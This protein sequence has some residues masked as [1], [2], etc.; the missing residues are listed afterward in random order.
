MKAGRIT[1]PSVA[2]KF[3][4]LL[5]RAGLV[6]IECEQDAEQIVS[7]QTGECRDGKLSALVR[8]FRGRRLLL[9]G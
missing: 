5:D 8:A 6:G 1:A 3:V 9:S 2:D 4:G 7:P